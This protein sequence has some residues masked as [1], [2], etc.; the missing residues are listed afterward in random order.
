[1]EHVSLRALV[2]WSLVAALVCALAW[3]AIMWVAL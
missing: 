3:Y 1:V 2:A